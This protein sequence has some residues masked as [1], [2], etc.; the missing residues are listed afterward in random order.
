[1]VIGSIHVSGD[2]IETH[3]NSYRIRDITAASRSRPFLGASVI[4][5]AGLSAFGLSFADLLYLHELVALFGLAASSLGVGLYLGQLKLLSRDLRGSDI[6][7]VIWGSYGHLDLIR[8]QIVMAMARGGAE[9][10]E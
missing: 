8:R 5:A 9:V 10:T 3:R 2:Y 6:A 7:C 1:M 4:V